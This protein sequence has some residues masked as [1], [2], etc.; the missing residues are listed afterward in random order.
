MEVD[1]YEQDDDV[2][3]VEDDDNFEVM[4]DDKQDSDNSIMDTQMYRDLENVS[5]GTECI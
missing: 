2:E 4:E 3:I 1:D 5:I